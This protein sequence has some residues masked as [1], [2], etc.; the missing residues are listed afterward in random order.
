MASS[1]DERYVWPWTGIVANIFGKPK[2]EPVECDSMYWL[3]KFEQYKPEEAYVLHCAEDPTGYVVLEFGTEWTGFSQMMKLDTDF[4]VD[5][6]GKK[7]Y[8][9]SRK[10]GYSS[11]LFGWC[12]QAEDYNSEGLV[13]NFLRQ[14]A[15]LKT[16]SMVAQESL[17]EK[18]ETLDHLY[19][20]IGSV[21]KKISEMESK[22]IEDYMSLDKMMK[23]IEKKRDLLHQTRAE[24]TEKQMKARS[25][26]LSLLEKHQ[27]EK[28][29]VS[30]ALLKLEKEM[31]NEQ[32]LNL[33]IAELEEQLKVLKCVNLEEADHENKRKIEIEE[34]EEKLEDMIFD[35]SVKDD[36][37]QALKK[38]VQEA[39]I[40]LEDARQ[41][42]IKELPQF[43][44]GVTKIQIKKIG[45]VSARSFKKVCMNRYKNNKKASSESVKLCAK[46]QKE[47]LDSTWHPFKIVD[48]EGKEIQ[49]EIDENDPKLLSLKNDLGEEAYVAVVTA[50]KELHEYHNSDDAENTHNSSE[51]QVIPEIWDSENG[52]R[53]TVTEAL[54]YISNR[55]IKM[56]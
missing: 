33:E 29:A 37:N 34:I 39:K 12:A 40:E 16:T 24:A 51:K 21:N 32:K 48:V 44:K 25:D 42:I 18:T 6:H 19:G 46:W 23:E 5:H 3:R 38:K 7:D 11:G 4:L 43:L 31:G 27:M 36:E 53:A 54:K 14:K 55:V 45:E 47:I 10:M 35:M 22:Y 9:E 30:D 28:K 20:E 1:S 56:R 17:N 13:G 50:L 49:E 8:Y 41:Q 52:R 2:H 15:E 26:V